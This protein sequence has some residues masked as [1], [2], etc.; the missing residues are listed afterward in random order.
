MLQN[1][2]LKRSGS[3]S[4][5]HIITRRK[6]GPSKQSM[7]GFLQTACIESSLTFPG[8]GENS[9]RALHFV[10]TTLRP[11][12][13]QNITV[14]TDESNINAVTYTPTPTKEGFSLNIQ[15]SGDNKK[16]Q[17]LCSSPNAGTSVPSIASVSRPDLPEEKKTI[18]FPKL[19]K[20]EN[21]I[22]IITSKTE[23]LVIDKLSHVLNLHVGKSNSEANSSSKTNDPVGTNLVIRLSTNDDCHETTQVAD[24]NTFSNSATIKL[25]NQLDY[26]TFDIASTSSIAFPVKTWQDLYAR[27]IINKNNNS[28]TLPLDKCIFIGT[29]KTFTILLHSF[30]NLYHIVAFISKP[31]PYCC[32]HFKTFT[33]LLHSFQKA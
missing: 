26:E 29:R 14:D 7:L 33:I 32:I 13:Q 4:I 2:H 8:Q 30:Q 3:F 17:V 22:V 9:K 18:N 25:E 16:I 10:D 6:P 19:E 28:E 31:S 24:A 21:S 12:N 1:G 27:R 5:K 15:H 23:G 20:I 11:G